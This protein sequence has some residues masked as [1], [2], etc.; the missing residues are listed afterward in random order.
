MKKIFDYIQPGQH[1]NWDNKYSGSSDD[2]LSHLLS[3]GVQGHYPLFFKEDLLSSRSHPISKFI[4]KKYAKSYLQDKLKE[5]TQYKSFERK[6]LVISSMPQEKRYRLINLF[7]K[8]VEDES[9]SKH[10]ELH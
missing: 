5:M 2:Q 1:V 6:K 10:E 8:L 7:M 4:T 9:L 3:L